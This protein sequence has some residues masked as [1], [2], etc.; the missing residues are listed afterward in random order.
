[1]SI[2]SFAPMQNETFFLP[3]SAQKDDGSFKILLLTVAGLLF[4]VALL[5]L[6]N[7]YMTNKSIRNFQDRE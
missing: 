6:A 5:F 7:S 1:M 3:I 2:Q 4:L